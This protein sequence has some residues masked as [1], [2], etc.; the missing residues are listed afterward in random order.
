MAER[1][2]DAREM[3]PPEPLEATLAALDG[4][5]D[6]DQV[7]LLL[8]REPFP[9]Y[10]HLRERGFGWTTTLEA[11]GTYVIRISRP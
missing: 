2:V 10:R 3:L 7:V 6:G 5:P 9:L 4:L 11:D 8:P 1:V